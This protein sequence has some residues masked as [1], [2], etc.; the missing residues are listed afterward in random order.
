MFPPAK[1]CQSPNPST[2]GGTL[3]GN[4]VSADRISLGRGWNRAGWAIIQRLKPLQEREVQTDRQTDR[5][6]WRK[7]RR[8]DGGRC[9]TDAWTSQGRQLLLAT[10]RSQKGGGKTPQTLRREHGA[11]SAS[12]AR[13]R[14][15][16]L[17]DGPFLLFSAPG[18][19]PQR[20]EAANE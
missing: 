20:M 4:T 11:P 14:P 12:A 7:A 19:W 1:I 5:R 13:L 3:W 16:E 9:K 10:G 6:A 18:L 17:R 8:E 2:C 15:P